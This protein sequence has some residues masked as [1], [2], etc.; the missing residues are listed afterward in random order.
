MEWR[1]AMWEGLKTSKLDTHNMGNQHSIKKKK[2]CFFKQNV[3]NGKMTTDLLFCS[4]QS[5][6]QSRTWFHWKSPQ[7]QY[8]WAGRNPMEM[9]VH[10][11]SWSRRIQHSN[12]TLQQWTSLLATYNLEILT[13]SW[14][15]LSLITPDY[16]E[17][18]Y[19][20]LLEQIPSVLLFH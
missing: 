9:S 4:S 13:H 8:L 17:T 15:L 1:F 19:Q 7:I 12:Q 5:L 2:H 18:M 11:W 16:R 10:I 6:E 20:R 3:K 14:S